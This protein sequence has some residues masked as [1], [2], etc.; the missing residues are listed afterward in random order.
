MWHLHRPEGNVPCSLPTELPSEHK[1]P[2]ALP[3]MQ[4]ASLLFKETA[5]NHDHPDTTWL[6]LRLEEHS[7]QLS[8]PEALPAAVSCP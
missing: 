8:R 5:R 1:D 3:H 4:A 6:Q 7:S 2:S